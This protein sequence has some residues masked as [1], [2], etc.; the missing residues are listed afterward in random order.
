[1]SL[2][3][4]APDQSLIPPA[5][6]LR[7]QIANLNPRLRAVGAYI[8]ALGTLHDSDATTT[9]EGMTIT[10]PNPF[11]EFP[12]AGAALR[13][14]Q[15][16]SSAYS[17][18]NNLYFRWIISVVQYGYL[19]DATAGRILA[20]YQAMPADG[21]TLAQRTEVLNLFG[22]L[23]R[24]LVSDRN[25]LVSAEESFLAARA[26]LEED[27]NAL[28]E[29]A[30][31]MNRVIQRYEERIRDEVLKLSLYPAT[32]G[33]A[34]IMSKAGGAQLEHL[35][36]ARESI[37]G[38]TDA[39]GKAHDELS[40]LAGHLLTVIGKYQGVEAGLKVAEGNAFVKYLDR[41]Q[42]NIARETWKALSTYA[43]EAMKS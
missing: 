3:A 14:A 28:G 20:H 6:A 41:F 35:R 2:A 10:L 38:A 15:G 17:A 22:S 4:A 34:N 12:E 42:L 5:D 11:K 7:S 37:T 16:R 32:R 24:A 43:M 23:V 21:P 1:M 13:R 19:F 29:G 30:P 25:V 36:K 39:C 33:L 27:R 26:L 9:T 40:L 18:G 8:G 31:A